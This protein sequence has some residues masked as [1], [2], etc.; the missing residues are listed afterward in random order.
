MEELADHFGI[1]QQRAMAILALK[2]REHAARAAGLPL[3]TDLAGE[4]S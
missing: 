4:L 3:R 2:E 1:R